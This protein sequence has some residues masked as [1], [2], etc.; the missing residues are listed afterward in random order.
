MRQ[1]IC[2]KCGAVINAESGECPNCGA[3]YYILPQEEPKPAPAGSIHDADETQVWRRPPEGEE[4]VR[5]YTPQHSRSAAEPTQR[6]GQGI[7]SGAARP[8]AGGAS[9]SGQAG[10]GRVQGQGGTIPV[11]QF[12]LDEEGR[13]IVPRQASAQ[14]SRS[15]QG[16][17]QARQGQQQ[18]RYAQQSGSRSTGSGGG[19][20]PRRGD[21]R[22]KIFVVAALAFVAVLTVVLC[23]IGGVFNF[24]GDEPQEMPSVVGETVER[25]TETLED[26]GLRVSVTEMESDEEPGIVLDQSIEAG[27]SVNRGDSVMLVVSAAAEEEPEETAEPLTVPPIT[28]MTYDEALQVVNAMGL[29]LTKTEDVYSETVPEGQIVTQSP[30]AGTSIQEGETIIVT[31]SMGPEPDPTH[32]ITVIAGRGG[33]VSPNGQVS[34]TEGQSQTFTIT[35][36]SGYEIREVRVDGE[37]VG[38]VSSYTFSNVTESHSIYA[39]FQAVAETPSPSPSPTPPVVTDPPATPTVTDPPA[40]TPA[41]P[42]EPVTGEN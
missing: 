3:V 23:L 1:I 20:R 16:G 10:G 39:V 42:E 7:N 22:T 33:S 12:S 31:L 27:E 41:V 18:R 40:E 35:P 11:T 38:A 6:T 15:A 32:T 5:V 28:N 36:D 25:A 30:S 21:G 4:D 24:G 9:P 17:G 37:N 13:P 26:M 2:K 29:R 19:K 14:G 34:V 8:A